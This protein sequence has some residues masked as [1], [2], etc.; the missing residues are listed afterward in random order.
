VIEREGCRE[1]MTKDRVIAI[2]IVAVVIAVA[3]ALAIFAP[4]PLAFMAEQK[5]GI[6]DV[7]LGGTMAGN[8]RF[9]GILASG[10][11]NYLVVAWLGYGNLYVPLKEEGPTAFWLGNYR[12]EVIDWNWDCVIIEVKE[13]G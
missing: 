13:V 4:N 11:K 1:G 12:F 9:A 2:L 5:Y 7:N 3:L 8:Y 10:G 6:R